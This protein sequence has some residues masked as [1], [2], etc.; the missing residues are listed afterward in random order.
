[1]KTYKIKQIA[2]FSTAALERIVCSGNKEWS[3]AA[4]NELEKRK[5]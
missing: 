4:M 3:Q 5:K 1:M 2:E